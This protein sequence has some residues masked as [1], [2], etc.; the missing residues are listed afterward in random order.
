MNETPSDIYVQLI[1]GPA[2]NKTLLTSSL[3]IGSEDTDIVVDHPHLSPLHCTVF[4]RGGIVS[5]IDHNSD[6]GVLINGKRIAPNKM[7]MLMQEDTIRCGELELKLY[8]EG[9]SAPIVEESAQADHSD[10]TVVLSHTTTK[11]LD[12]TSD[13]DDDIQLTSTQIMPLELTPKP[14]APTDSSAELQ[15]V[16]EKTQVWTPM[17]QAE[18]GEPT[19]TKVELDL[20]VPP[21]AQ[22]QEQQQQ[23]PIIQ[24]DTD[25]LEPSTPEEKPMVQ[26]DLEFSKHS[27]KVGNKIKTQEKK[28]VTKFASQNKLKPKRRRSFFVDMSSITLPV[29]LS[30][31]LID[32][33]LS[34][35]LVQL[36]ISENM[37]EE[38][39]TIQSLSFFGI[40][41][42]LE[43]TKIN[44]D[45]GHVQSIIGPYVA[46]FLIIRVVSSFIFGVSVGQLL[47]GVQS[48]GNLLIKRIFAPLR[49]ALGVLTGPFLIFDLPAIFARK[50]IKEVLSFSKLYQAPIL[51]YLLTLIGPPLV[52]ALCYL[53]PM[54][55]GD[56]Q[57]QPVHM[58]LKTEVI[59]IAPT[60]QDPDELS[61]RL[62]D[63]QFLDAAFPVGNKDRTLGFGLQKTFAE[64][65]LR[66]YPSLKVLYHNPSLTINWQ[67]TKHIDLPSLLSKA[68]NEKNGWIERR[69]PEI[70]KFI[71]HEKFNHPAF[72]NEFKTL[73]QDAFNLQWKTLPLTLL[74]YGPF[75]VGLL[76]FRNAFFSQEGIDGIITDFKILQIQKDYVLQM[77]FSSAGKTFGNSSEQWLT[78]GM[79][80]ISSLYKV[81]IKS[82]SPEIYEEGI[83]LIKEKFFALIKL[84]SHPTVPRKDVAFPQDRML[85]MGEI[86]DFFSQGQRKI[87]EQAFLLPNISI[88]LKKILD[89]LLWQKNLFLLEEY[90]RELVRLRDWLKELGERDMPPSSQQP[91]QQFLLNLDS[92]VQIIDSTMKQTPVESTPAP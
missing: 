32:V 35:R 58:D 34:I 75:Y 71:H 36:L 70:K 49:E 74:Y 50:T 64:N 44:F 57:Y 83:K 91:F 84:S 82:Q 8:Y 76:D 52:F 26:N 37:L 72:I 5:V 19:A 22:E 60:T 79:G 87:L 92:F 90:K 46:A 51:S 33:I 10:S 88:H 39:S 63:V 21:Q 42:F 38:I 13:G 29:R 11:D 27:I 66:P 55:E 86:I 81:D 40:D 56:A 4:N 24:V 2:Q 28:L 48:E 68:V 77:Q 18:E 43:Q 14:E 17:Q 23:Q 53:G 59:T 25:E 41:F 78:L 1:G 89:K 30:A 15:D 62:L 20:E 12:L 31:F 7:I 69:F 54:L 67:K 16:D 45:P 73:C 65:K 47:C 3:T 85:T 80:P 6:Y 61:P 9:A